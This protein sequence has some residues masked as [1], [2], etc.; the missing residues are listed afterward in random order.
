MKVFN[1]IRPDGFIQWIRSI[2][3]RIFGVELAGRE[4]LRLVQIRVVVA[5][6]RELL[7]KRKVNDQCLQEKEGGKQQLGCHDE[8]LGL[9]LPNSNF[10]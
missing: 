1:A 5:R 8:S 10:R 2:V 3:E 7:R 4:K 6:E 9:L